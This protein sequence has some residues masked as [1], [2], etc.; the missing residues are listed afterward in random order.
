MQMTTKRMMSIYIKM[1]PNLTINASETCLVYKA[2]FA[3]SAHYEQAVYQY[4]SSWSWFLPILGT[5]NDA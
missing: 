1:S 4:I 5:M 2:V 3:N